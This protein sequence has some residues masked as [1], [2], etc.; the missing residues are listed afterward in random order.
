M[1]LR[2]LKERWKRLS[3]ES[4][5]SFS[6]RF[7]TLPL[8]TPTSNTKPS[9]FN[10][11]SLNTMMKLR[12]LKERGRWKRLS[13]ESFFSFS[14]R[15]RTLPLYTPTSKT[16]NVQYEISEQW[17]NCENWKRERTMKTAVSSSKKRAG[18]NLKREREVVSRRKF[19][20]LKNMYTCT[21]EQ[22]TYIN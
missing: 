18:F 21:I 1:K 6:L 3:N 2:K 12:T 4:F 22:Y 20:F 9:L 7:R 8:Y 15:F 5:F 19:E 17:W 10:M 14:L 11:K 13:N 16:F